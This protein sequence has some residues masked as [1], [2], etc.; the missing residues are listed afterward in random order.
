MGNRPLAASV[1]R[2]SIE[3]CSGRRG[4]A[5]STLSQ[6]LRR[7]QPGRDAARRRRRSV[8][9]AI[10][11]VE[12]RHPVDM[13]VSNAARRSRRLVRPLE[14]SSISCRGMVDEADTKALTSAVVEAI[15]EAPAWV[16]N[17][18]SGVGRMKAIGR[19]QRLCAACCCSTFNHAPSTRRTLVTDVAGGVRRR[20][21]LVVVD[22]WVVLVDHGKA[23]GLAQPAQDIPGL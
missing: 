4:R 16:G 21:P 23:T 15:D 7:S 22:R 10:G 17:R 1:S 12:M 14:G 20:R 9:G 19:L 13:R 6:R 3:C 5:R 2:A 11:V 8:L 18:R